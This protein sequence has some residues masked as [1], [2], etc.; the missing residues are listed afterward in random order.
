MTFTKKRI[1]EITKASHRHGHYADLNGGVW[2]KCPECGEEVRA[3]HYWFGLP[4][5]ATP[6]QKIKAAMSY[7]LT[8][9][10]GQD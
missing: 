1:A 10:C 7:H 5:T 6:L 4:I 3:E 2:V 9:Y 8:N